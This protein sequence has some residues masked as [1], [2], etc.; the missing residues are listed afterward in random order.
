[1]LKNLLLKLF[2]KMTGYYNLEKIVK[3]QDDIILDFKRI[4]KKM[5][6]EAKTG[7]E[8]N[9]YGGIEL[10]KVALRKVIADTESILDYEDRVIETDNLIVD[11]IENGG[12]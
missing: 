12:K 11:F 6:T 8:S 10:Y 5:R 2:R 9:S 3:M 1:M 7:L 4:A